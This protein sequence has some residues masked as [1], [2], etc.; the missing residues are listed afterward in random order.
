[1]N[2][3]DWIGNEQRYVVLLRSKDANG[4]AISD[5]I[6]AIDSIAVILLLLY[7]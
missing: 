2:P 7:P 6:I 4:S 3:S 5:Y 1:V